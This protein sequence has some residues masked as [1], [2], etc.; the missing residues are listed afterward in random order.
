MKIAYPSGALEIGPVLVDFF[1]SFWP[2]TYYDIISY[3]LW[4]PLRFPCLNVYDIRFTLIFYRIH[5]L[6]M[7]FVFTRPEHIRLPPLLSLVCIVLSL[8]VCTV[9]SIIVFVFIFLILYVCPSN[10][11][12]WFPFCNLKSYCT[13]GVN[14][15]PTKYLKNEMIINL[16]LQ[17]KISFH[18]DNNDHGYLPIVVNTSRSFPRSWL[19]T[20]SRLT[21]WVLLLEQE[22]LPFPNTAGI[23]GD[24][25]T[26]SLVVCVCFVD[27]C[28]SF[29]TF[30]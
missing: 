10:Y 3:L 26:R 29:Y 13:M 2:I 28:L 6:S 18:S 20:V 23:S 1:L 30:S 22:L 17:N 5:V 11:G 16:L 8:V 9:I 4:C 21:R 25:F 12:I 7:W 14:S 15:S 27:R 19:V 24:F